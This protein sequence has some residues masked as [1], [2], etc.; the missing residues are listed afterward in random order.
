MRSGK[1]NSIT[2]VNGFLVGNAVD[3]IIKTGTTVFTNSKPFSAAVHTMGGAPGT[4]ETDLLSPDRLVQKIDALV[5]SG[6]S[7]FGLEAASSVTNIL[8]KE[9]RGFQVE[10]QNVPIVP[11][12]I[13]FDLLNGGK[14]NWNINPYGKLGE[15]AYNNASSDFMIGSEGAGY[16]AT[17]G[18]LKGGLGTSSI[19]TKGGYIVGALLCVNSLGSTVRADSST[20]WA[21][22]FEI[23]NE[24]GNQ[25]Q[26]GNID[27][28]N[29]S[30]GF[31]LN[32]PL[33]TNTT[34]GIVATDANLNQSELTRIAIASHDGIARAIVPSHTLFDGDLLFAA[35][36]GEKEIKNRDEVIYEIAHCAAICVSRAI[37]R[38]IYEAT[39]ELGDKVLTWK[40]K[41]KNV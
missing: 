24:F 36:N 38:G 25:S 15:Q 3:K 35:S 39:P 5:L 40:E 28:P 30:K 31:D 27:P 33:R 23:N 21:A 14:K 2:D 4:R 37:A 41:W 29:Q 17:T 11:S 1:K 16:G 8:A 20:F 22:P 32:S 34:I 18:D 10:D 26:V 7:A 19:I 13:L 12:A 6:G 9:G